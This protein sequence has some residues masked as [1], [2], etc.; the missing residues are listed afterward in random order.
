MQVSP[1]EIPANGDSCH[2][3][4]GRKPYT[5]SHV[6]F[7]LCFFQLFVQWVEYSLQIICMW[8]TGYKRLHGRTLSNYQNSG[9]YISL[10]ST[11]V[12]SFVHVS[13]QIIELQEH[14]CPILMYEPKFFCGFPKRRCLH[15][16]YYAHFL[17]IIKVYHLTKFQVLI[18]SG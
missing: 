16:F 10:N 6:V 17:C 13:I 14:A 2:P 12:Q 18:Y 7:D 5:Q 11:S 8:P 4:L 3:W 9:V 1:S 15:K